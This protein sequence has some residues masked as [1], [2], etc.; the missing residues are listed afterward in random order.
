MREITLEIDLGEGGRG[1]LRAGPSLDHQHGNRI[2]SQD[3]QT[4][5]D[6]ETRPAGSAVSQTRPAGRAV[7]QGKNSGML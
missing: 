4:G 6:G 3:Q 5:K 7:S 2:Q 1:S